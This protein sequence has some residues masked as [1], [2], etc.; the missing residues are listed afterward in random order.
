MCGL[1]Q[2]YA[3]IRP[4]RISLKNHEGRG[5]EIVGEARPAK[6]KLKEAAN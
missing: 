1:C 4:M 6:W 2:R 5:I 3:V